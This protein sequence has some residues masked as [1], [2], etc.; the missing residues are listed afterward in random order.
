MA[1]S[2]WIPQV[3]SVLRVSSGALALA[4][5]TLLSS[6]C[7]DRVSNAELREALVELVADGQVMAFENEIVELTTS[8]TIGD[9]VAAVA[10]EIRAFVESQLPCSTVT[11]EGAHLELDFGELGDACEY[12]GHTFA[13][14]I[15][16]DLTGDADSITVDHMFT[17]VTNGEVT[18][19]GAKQVVWTTKSRAIATD[20]AWKTDE[21]AVEGTSERVQTLLDPDAGVRGG[22]E[23]NGARQWTGESG[24][25]ELS[26]DGVEIRW[27]DPI[28]QAGQYTLTIP[29]GNQLSLS[30]TRIDEDTIEAVIAV[31]ARTRVFHV[32]SAGG[33]SDE[34]AG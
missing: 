26:I 16:L 3:R 11:V 12:N 29:R 2:A 14:V 7:F 21:R 28:P 23:I 13:G 1:Y 4:G 34:S 19:D 17:G 27:M 5:V 30:F 32:N 10:E 20:Y 33:V 18:L 6:A 8:F 9:G 15:E 22:I 25:W 24:D 31:G